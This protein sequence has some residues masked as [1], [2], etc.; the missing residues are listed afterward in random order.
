ML[1]PESNHPKLY[2]NADSYWKTKSSHVDLFQ[3][4]IGLPTIQILRIGMSPN[5]NVPTY[6]K[7]SLSYKGEYVVLSFKAVMNDDDITD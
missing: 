6:T 4:V 1:N 5:P 2:S 3:L 7:V